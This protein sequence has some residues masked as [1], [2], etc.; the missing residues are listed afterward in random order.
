M[1]I[2]SSGVI[3]LRL[4]KLA[5]FTKTPN[6]GDKLNPYLFHRL[7]PGFFNDDDS[8]VFLG[9]GSILGN[10]SVSKLAR[11]Q[12]VFSSGY[13]YG[14]PPKDLNPFEFWCVRGPETARLLNLPAEMAIGD[15]ALLLQKL[16][17]P[18]VSKKHKYS[19]IPHEHARCYYPGWRDI[20]EAAG[21]HWIDPYDDVDDVIRQIRESEVILTE[22]MHGAI[23]ADVFRVPWIPLVLYSSTAS[24]KWKDYTA[25]MEME[26]QPVIFPALSDRKSVTELVDYHL[27][28]RKVPLSASLASII[29]CIYHGTVMRKRRHAAASLLGRTARMPGF[30]SDADVLA[31]RTER[32]HKRLLELAA[33]YRE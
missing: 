8:I 5:Y 9:I 13:G 27:K 12:L 14:T 23:V 15:G 29:G 11:K 19:F 6:F 2:Y 1:L 31:D 16:E 20:A 7:L 25:S 30:L 24:F 4:M 33:A 10:L 3:Y 28:Q 26:Y 18:K 32:L 17:F 21:L 22:A